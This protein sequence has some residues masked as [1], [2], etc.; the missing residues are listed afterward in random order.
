[1]LLCLWP[2]YATGIDFN[3]GLL[4]NANSRFTKEFGLNVNFSIMQKIE[5]TRRALRSNQADMVWATIDSY[6]TEAEGLSA[7]PDYVKFAFA[8]DCST[9]GDV[10]VA[11]GGIK[12]IN[13]LKGKTVAF[14]G[15]SPSSSL[16]HSALR[17]AGMTIA[18]IIPL[19][20]GGPEQ[21]RDAFI[22]N[23]ADAAVIWSPDD[24]KC[25]ADVRGSH[26]LT[27]TKTANN[28]IYNV[29]L[30]KKS[31]IAEHR[32]RVVNF[33]AGWMTANAE[34]NKGGKEVRERTAQ[35]L[36]DYMGWGSLEEAMAALD[37]AKFLTLGDNQNLFGMNKEWNGALGSEIYGKFSAMY[38]NAGTI[39]KAPPSWAE[40]F[41]PSIIAE[42]AKNLKG[43]EHQ[44]A[45]PKK[46]S[47]VTKDI[48]NEPALTHKSITV[49][50][51]TGSAVLDDEAMNTIEREFGDVV[52]ENASA[53][54]RVV[55]NTDNTGNPEQNR[56]LSRLRANAVKDFLVKEYDSD[57]NRFIVIGNGPDRAIEDGIEGANENYR[58]TD[59]ELVVD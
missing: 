24:V 43:K 6:T 53:R 3:R 39:D 37:N 42:A 28:L 19:E 46:F 10:M 45:E 8:T 30:V 49:T 35:A 58:S 54:I 20:L 33:F 31:Y 1:V 50:F 57:P 29:F 36:V 47:P 59:F 23:E 32:D 26:V 51:A 25:L 14:G 13:D 2:G 9:G 21:A 5:D 18:D 52:K 12:S 41:D 56:K 7:H 17:S 38:K 48:A 27:S 15:M 55:G 34:Y 4:A 16:L 22:N 40:V 11:K 44:P